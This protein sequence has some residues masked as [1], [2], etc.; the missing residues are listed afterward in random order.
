[1]F[2]IIKYSGVMKNK[3]PEKHREQKFM[4]LEE[5]KKLPYLSDLT[6]LY[7]SFLD[8]NREAKI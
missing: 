1:L 8:F 3:E 4:A 6:L 7:L 2:E 5:I